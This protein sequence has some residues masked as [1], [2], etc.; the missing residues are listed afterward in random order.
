MDVADERLCSSEEA[1]AS[2]S[3]ATVLSAVLT[4]PPATAPSPETAEPEEAVVV[5]TAHSEAVVVDACLDRLVHARKHASGAVRKHMCDE[6]ADAAS[7]ALG[8]R[9]SAAR[10][11]ARVAVLEGYQRVLATLLGGDHGVTQRTPEWYAARMTMI[12]ASDVAQCLGCAK[13]GTLREFYVKKCGSDEEQ[14]P[15]N[16]SLPPLK[17]GSMFEPVAQALYAQLNGTRVHEFGLLRHPTVPHLGAS[18]DGI[19]ETGIMLE[20]KC[21]YRRKIVAGEVPLQY[22]Y[23]VQAQLDVCQ[24]DECDYFECEFAEIYAGGMP[25]MGGPIALDGTPGGL[26]LQAQGAF[27]EV[28]TD[29]EDDEA[30]P[31]DPVLTEYVYPDEASCAGCE[32]EDVDAWVRQE[33]GK[34]RCETQRVIVH[35]WRLVKCQTVRVLRDPEFVARMLEGVAAAWTKV[36]E[37][38]ADREAYVRDVLTKPVKAAVATTRASASRTG[39]AAAAAAAGRATK[40]SKGSGSHKAAAA[41]DPFATFAFVDEDA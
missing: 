16:A 34:T 24:L 3:L 5:R 39:T 10:V 28:I 22:Y 12:T 2:A 20:I 7:L 27:L 29:L 23:Q 17:W 9:V 36:G 8:V 26:E 25:P 11:A 37:Y 38:R 19:T 18:P 21:P 31:R 40:V 15:F 41:A 33:V 1:S 6:I 35:R 4:T 14:K 32:G 30:T 13:F